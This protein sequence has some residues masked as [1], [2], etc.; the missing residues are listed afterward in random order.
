MF[1]LLAQKEIGKE[2][3]LWGV[4]FSRKD[5]PDFWK[6]TNLVTPF[7]AARTNEGAGG[8]KVAWRFHLPILNGGLPQELKISD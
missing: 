6:K 7:L 8:G 3:S 5:Y 4:K 2:A 1:L